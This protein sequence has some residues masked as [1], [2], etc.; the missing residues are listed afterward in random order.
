MVFSSV[1]RGVRRR[2]VTSLMFVSSAADTAAPP[3]MVVARRAIAAM[4][5]RTFRM[6]FPPFKVE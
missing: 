2:T 5:L 4:V 6:V 1:I 3:I